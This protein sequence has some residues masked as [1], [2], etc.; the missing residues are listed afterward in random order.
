MQTSLFLS[1]LPESITD[2]EIRTWFITNTPTLQPHQIKSITL[3]SSSHCAFVN[4]KNRK[5]AEEAAMRCAARVEMGGVEVKVAWGRSR[6]K[7]AP[8]AASGSAG[9][10]KAKAA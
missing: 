8:G 7:K 9:G 4:F 6:P 2:A 3:V 10:D 5:A 1:S